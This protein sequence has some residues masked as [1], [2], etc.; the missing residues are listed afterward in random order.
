[1]YRPHHV[2]LLSHLPQDSIVRRANEELRALLDKVHLEQEVLRNRVRVAEIN[3]LI[4]N[5]RE[6]LDDL[7]EAATQDQ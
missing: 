7:V 3:H 4:D 1:M 2:L 5:L 6:Q